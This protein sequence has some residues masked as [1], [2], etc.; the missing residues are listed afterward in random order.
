LEPNGTA[1]CVVNVDSAIPLD[2]LEAIRALPNLIYAKT[3]QV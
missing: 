2:I 1:V 3:V